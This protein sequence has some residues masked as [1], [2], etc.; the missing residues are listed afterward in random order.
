MFTPGLWNT[1]NTEIASGTTIQ[2]SPSGPQPIILHLT[3]R[4]KI[5]PELFP[6]A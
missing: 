5:G 1:G 3:R 6:D 4:Y 2:E